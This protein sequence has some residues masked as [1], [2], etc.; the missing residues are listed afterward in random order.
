MRIEDLLRA[1]G[2][3]K[4]SADVK[5]ADLTRYQPSAAEHHRDEHQSLDLTALNHDPNRNIP[6]K[7]GDV[8]SVPQLPASGIRASSSAME[9]ASS[10]SAPVQ[11][12]DWL[13][14]TEIA[15]TESR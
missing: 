12:V 7:D 8:L 11:R 14:W 6:L 15:C 5:D 2:G 13:Y 4:R 3:P 9:A 10:A 1:S